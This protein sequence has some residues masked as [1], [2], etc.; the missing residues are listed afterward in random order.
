MELSTTFSHSTLL[1]GQIR[2][3]LM[4]VEVFHCRCVCSVNVDFC[5]ALWLGKSVV[6]DSC[7]ASTDRK[8]WDGKAREPSGPKVGMLI[9][10]R[11]GDGEEACHRLLSSVLERQLL[12]RR[13]GIISRHRWTLAVVL[14][15]YGQGARLL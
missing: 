11:V 9:K 14:L 10:P 1:H 3:E 6:K 13:E 4:G 2:R 7:L 15:W 8:N 12:R 5:R